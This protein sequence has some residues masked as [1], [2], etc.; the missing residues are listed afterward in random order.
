MRTLS[1]LLQGCD[2]LRVYEPGRLYL[3]CQRCGTVT[4]GL[5]GPV[6]LAQRPVVTVRKL[7]PKKAKALR[8]VKAARRTA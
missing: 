1:C 3:R 7:R 8:V 6:S 5:R 4:P 2:W